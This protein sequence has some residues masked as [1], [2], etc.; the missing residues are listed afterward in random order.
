MNKISVR[1]TPIGNKI[2]IEKIKTMKH[3]IC[4]SS[5]ERPIIQKFLLSIT[6]NYIFCSE[7]NYQ[8]IS[9]IIVILSKIY[10]RKKIK[11]HKT[12]LGKYSYLQIDNNTDRSKYQEEGNRRRFSAYPLSFLCDIHFLIFWKDFLYEISYLL[13]NKE[14]IWYNFIHVNKLYFYQIFLK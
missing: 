13:L 10:P 6:T 2:S 5:F 11:L 3:M 1:I 8:R 9:Q 7:N 4:S 12:N 14:F